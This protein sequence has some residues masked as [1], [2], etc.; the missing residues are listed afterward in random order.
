MEGKK[1]PVKEIFTAPFYCAALARLRLMGG[2]M[3][4][5]AVC[6][7][8]ICSLYATSAGGQA[9]V[10]TAVERAVIPEGAAASVL[11][12]ASASQSQIVISPSVSGLDSAQ[13]RVSFSPSSLT[14]SADRSSASFNVLV[15]DNNEPQGSSRAFNVNLG[16]GL[17][18]LTF[19]IPPN[20]LTAYAAERVEFTPEN[21]RATRTMMINVRP[22]L[23]GEKSFIVFS[24]DPRIRVNTVLI[25]PAQSPFSIELALRKGTALGKEE[26][27]NLNISHLDS[28][29]PSTQPTAQAQLSAQRHNCG[30]KADSAVACWGF[31]G[32]GRTSPTASRQGVSV[33]TRFLSVSAGGAHSCGIKAN[34]AVACW[35]DDGSG[36]ARPAS[37]A[38]VRANAR[39]LSVNAGSHHTCGIKAD[40]MVA[41]WGNGANDRTNPT[42]SRQGVSANTRF[43]S[44]SA[45]DHHTC[46]I[47]ADGAVACWGRN[48]NNQ[49]NPASAA[50]VSANT[51]FLA[52]S[53]GSLHTCGIKAD[54][55][56]ACWG[57]DSVNQARPASAAGVSANTRFLAVSAGQRHSCGIKADSAVACWGDGANGR[58]NPTASRQGV[59]ANTRFL[60][61][62]AGAS[63]SCGIKADGAVACWGSDIEDR[64]SPPS[65]SFSRAPDVLRLAEQSTLL[66]TQ[67]GKEAVR[68]NEVT[69]IRFLLSLLTLREGESTT[70]ALFEV[71]NRPT[72]PVTVTL[73]VEESDRQFLR[74]TPDQ[75]VIS[76]AGEVEI[77]VTANDNLADIKP[78][79]VR[80]SGKG[81]Y[82][83]STPTETVTV[84]IEDD[85]KDVLASATTAAAMLAD[86]SLAEGDTTTLTA[87]LED[88]LTAAATLTLSINNELISLSDRE[89]AFMRGETEAAVAVTASDNDLAD[90]DTR[91]AVITIASQGDNIN[92]DPSKVELIIE[93]NDEAVII[94][95]PERLTLNEGQTMEA[96]FAVIPPLAQRATIT[97]TPSG[98]GQIILS[99]TR[100]SVAARQDRIALSITAADDD[101]EE[102]ETAYTI[103]LDVAGHATLD[104]ERITVTVPANDQRVANLR[105]AD[106]DA[107]GMVAENAP[108]NTTVGITIQAANATAYALTDN[109]GGRFAI[110]SSGVVTVADGGLLDFEDA[111]THSIT[112]EARN[113]VNSQSASLTVSV[114]NVNEIALRD[115]E[116]ENNLVR[117]STGSVVIGMTLEAA[118]ADGARIV[119]WGLRQVVGVFELTQAADSSTQNIRIKTDAENL[120]SHKNAT[121]ELS[122][123]ARTEHDVATITFIIVFTEQAPVLVGEIM[124]IDGAPDE[125]AENAPANTTVGIT[126][127]AANATAYALTDNADGR[128]A[129]NSSGI[130]TVADGGPLDFE[131]A[132]THSITVEARNEVNSQS[133]SLTVSVINVNE[134]ALRDRE[135]E[136]NLVR[137]S[138]GSVVIGM[139]LE[140]AH[141]DGA[142]IV[143]WGLRQVVG[144][145]ELTQAA[146]SSTQN[147]RIKTDAEN[148]SSHKNATTELSVIARTEHDVATIT[149][150]IV[151]TEQAPVLVGEIM[152]I[153]G[154]PDEVAENAPANTTVGI[155]VQAANA[156]AY[157]LT[158]NA[159]GRF[160]INSSGIVTVADGGPLDFEDAA[161]HSITVE[162]RNEVNSQSASLTVSVINVNEIAL[163]DREDE[164]NLVR[165]STGSVVI[166]MTLE[167]AHA[168]GA[169]IVAW[170]LRQVVGVFELTQAAD[171][172][173]QNIRIKTD[174]EN[175]SSHKN[176]TT[177]LSVIARTEHDVAT[178]TFIIVFTEQAPVL[179]GEIMDIDGAPDEVAENAPAN[180]TVGITV[181]AAYATAY[182]LT[183]NADGRFAINSSG[184][185]TVADGGPLDFEDAATHSITVEARS[186]NDSRSMPFIIAVTDVNEFELTSV[187][188][189]DTIDN[190]L[191]EN[192]AASSYTGITLSAAD[193]DG[194]AM[195]TYALTDSNN[196]LF[197]ADIETGVVTLQG[198]LNYEQ[199]TR[200][201]IIAQA[202]SSDGSAPTT[203]AFTI[204]VT[205]INEI[206]LTDTNP[207]SDTVTAPLTPLLKA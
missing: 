112:V 47:K 171:S 195:V 126:V 30:I 80:L 99:S 175:L 42:A 110:N 157:A 164:N 20:D 53:A 187:A 178:I 107:G 52:V 172:S 16:S 38:G 77:S 28:W 86:N 165:A 5:G 35:G 191:P 18:L 143:A 76:E 11:V 130:V 117:A 186:I 202:M 87:R 150:I 179:V 14:L 43:L 192:A 185:V 7:S 59:S 60:A 100:L 109:A 147:I 57:S 188:D 141:A 61:V 190:A 33:N 81:G 136:N 49:A 201:T 193:E 13:T 55:A 32:A 162:A 24:E 118:H 69:N 114:I 54:G 62:S 51:R 132:A 139:T 2:K 133:A 58:T 123:I 182:A 41:C 83:R 4:L 44:V 67:G 196:G 63:H 88:P 153:D 207:A 144:V 21:E 17:P 163:R 56:V 169:R 94:A 85:N 71:P 93:P 152:D 108:A 204:A 149:F 79:L 64:A 177:E 97:A 111:A 92:P 135:D 22:Q 124:D 128:F 23:R 91:T 72:A 155:T 31:G 151:F 134:I 65:E 50:G 166:G 120:S 113:E 95:E 115:R 159:D 205:N 127:Q 70:L 36:Q 142:R 25:T 199:S 12:D 154:A 104:A 167:A 125:V 73:E 1:I 116:D 29:Q 121:T 9:A 183:D 103:D 39:F 68:L 156:T 37:A 46:G 98:E 45:G 6:A 203:A 75:P 34:G 131:D 105:D 180:T 102:P 66:T 189:A 119:A 40:S 194:S 173:T 8:L 74:F 129:I 106:G 200:H 78:I 82:I 90:A 15:E 10:R 170:G 122:V 84:I 101:A 27:L 137:A 19:I 168:D 145:F 26:S 198:Q 140:A 160:A 181:Q 96:V 158:D 148:L 197:I 89:I 174:A 161:T 3:R 206:T 176:A 48:D 146:G 138:T 184:I